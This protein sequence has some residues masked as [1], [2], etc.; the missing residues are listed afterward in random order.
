MSANHDQPDTENVVYLP[1]AGSTIPAD[2]DA[3]HT[4]LVRREP[5]EVEHV[6]EVLEGELLDEAASAELDAQLRAQRT[7]KLRQ[8]SAAGAVELAHRTGSYV[9]EHH[10]SREQVGKAGKA[11]GGWL[12][13][14]L[15]YLLRGLG[16]TVRGWWR[17][18]QVVEHREEQHAHS[19]VRAGKAELVIQHRSYRLIASLIIVAILAGST[20]FA[21]HLIPWWA[22]TVAGLMLT[23]GLWQAGRPAPVSTEGTITDDGEELIVF[24]LSD[25]HNTNQTMECLRRALLSIGVPVKPLAANQ[26]PWGWEVI[27]QLVGGAGK[28]PAHVI[29]KIEEL[30]TAIDVRQNGLLVQPH[31][32]RRA[33]MTLRC[34][35]SDPFAKMPPLPVYKPGSR[36][37]ADRIPVALRMDAHEVG[38]SP[39]A[40]HAIILAA[41]GGG[42]SIL[43]RL[44]VDG[45]GAANDVVLWDIDPSGVGQE[46]QAGLFALRALS[47]DDC[48]AA[49]RYGVAIAEARTRLLGRLGMGDEWQ[50]SPAHPALVI[51]LDEFPRLTK[52]G[53][54]LAVALLRVA[55]KAGVVLLFAS[56][57]AKKDSLGDSVAAEVAFK[58]GGPGLAAYQSRLLF[59]ENCIGEGWNPGAFKPKR[60]GRINDAGTF[61]FEGLTE[62]DEPIP[63]RVLFL[64][65]AEAKSR[66]H[67]YLQADRPALDADTLRAASLSGDQLCLQTSDLD[68]LAAQRRA[69][70]QDADQLPEPLQQLV[71]YLDADLDDDGREFVPTSE[72]VDELGLTAKKLALEMKR[73]GL[74]AKPTW[75]TTESG[76]KRQERGY[77]TADVRAAI[78][79]AHATDTDLDPPVT[80][81]P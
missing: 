44:L 10:P 33:R 4:E 77:R 18:V 70:E 71:D 7:T 56:Q 8:R 27:V 42:K 59:G 3:D 50:P 58:A 64:S 19:P 53:K 39:Q 17:W 54:D 43:I 38:M 21:G 11:A 5:G 62:G 14:H 34:I 49:L 47:P 31:A 73:F 26:R 45:L 9:R 24:P 1:S 68:A 12:G 23:G 72:L 30:E 75:I 40:T 63:A 29:A 28:K 41:S 74:M 65:N 22:W 79:R 46:A 61:F 51:V 80:P 55:R 32:D 35:E 78:D 69:H 13:R 37:I 2:Q 15:T 25:A 66:A 57:S 81:E 36:A 48:E 60:A 20:Y 6:G 52:T 67:R 76:E 16:H